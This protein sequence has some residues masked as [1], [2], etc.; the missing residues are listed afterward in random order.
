[1]R[2][3]YVR[4][5]F[6][7]FSLGG[8]LF[9]T[10]AGI[11]NSAAAAQTAVATATVTATVTPT[12]T[13]TATATVTSTGTVTPTISPTATLSKGLAV[14]TAPVTTTVAGTAAVSTPAATATATAT[15]A[16]TS[17]ATRAA[18]SAATFTATPLATGTPE[19]AAIEATLVESGTEE[20][21]ARPTQATPKAAATAVEAASEAA[22]AATAVETATTA[23]TPRATVAAAPTANDAA[24][25]DEPVSVPAPKKATPAPKATATQEAHTNATPAESPTGAPTGTLTATVEATATKAITTTPALT[26]EA[27]LTATVAAASEV[28]QS[29]VTTSTTSATAATELT[30]TETTTATVAAATEVTKTAVTTATTSATTA[31][32]L[33]KT[34][35]TTATVVA[36]TTTTA[37]TTAAVTTTATAPVTSTATTTA[38]ASVTTTAPVTTTAAAGIATPVAQ[39]RPS[40]TSPGLSHPPTDLACRGCHGSKTDV[41]T[42]SSGETVTLG[43][44]LAVLD[45]SAHTSFATGKQVACNDC[46][47]NATHYRYPHADNPAESRREFALAVSNNCQDCHY[48]HSPFHDTKQTEYTPPACVDCHGSHAIDHVEDITNT[49]PANCVKCHTDETIDW[50]T[51]L[52]APR[53]GFGTGA[54]GYIGSARCGGCH[55]DKYGTWQKT[56]H[57]KLIQNPVKDPEVVVG[58]F[59][60]SDPALTFAITD[61]AYTLGSRW[62]QLYLTQTVSNTFAILPAKWVVK[63]RQWEAYHPEG[64][65]TSDW[66]KECGSCHATGLDTQTWTFTEFGVG[67]ESCHGPGEA[68]AGNPKQVKLYTKVDDQVC[69]ACHSRGE[70]PD[71]H[72]FPATY[73]PGDTLTDHFTFTNSVEALWPDGSAKLHEQQY[74]DWQL[75]NTMVE[76]GKVNCVTC[77]SVHDT[78][79]AEGQVVEPL[80]KLCLDCHDLQRALV[81]HTPFHE[82]AM[83]KKD[84]LCTD[85]HMPKLA[86]NATPFDTH[87]HAF[88]QPDPQASVDHGGIANMPN[89]CNQCHTG[90]GETAAWAAQTIAFAKAKATPVPGAF[91]GPGPTPT[92]PPPPTPMA[93]VGPPAPYD[94]LEVGA[95]IRWSVI[96]GFWVVVILLLAWAYYRFRTRGAKNA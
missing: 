19:P 38:T 28:T 24:D 31:T 5:V 49:V 17:T 85:C 37:T 32:E 60:Q 87:S 77:H 63:T 68:H 45:A 36:T 8:L 95:W 40:M 62:A 69:G 61:V 75:G 33:T 14:A 27:T 41:L 12:V 79:V 84:F 42:F 52:I 6:I 74:M 13:P 59:T 4:I 43:I 86:T 35:A 2:S 48:P 50:A 92:S 9:L 1:M 83:Q 29:A 55:E 25:D 3:L 90:S 78:G 30:K 93:S 15:R 76:S 58:D 94:K 46:H 81:S 21:T 11:G 67:C 54:A 39:G 16:A 53:A 71:G 88:L 91:F 66:R 64:W 26:A 89:A 56:L 23:K 51:E 10:L 65:E 80:N 7:G 96:I 57:A 70:S 18:T 82:K 72:P 20:A 22:T 44:D 73:R 47:Q 34:E